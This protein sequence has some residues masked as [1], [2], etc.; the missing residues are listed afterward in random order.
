MPIDFPDSP[1][2]NQQFTAGDRTWTY[3]GTRWESVQI[4]AK[5]AYQTAV[6]NGFS[7]TEAEWVASLT[8]SD[9]DSAYTIAVSEGFVGTEAEWLESLKANY[10]ATAVSSNITLEDN[11]RY[12]V[13]TTAA[14]T[15]TLPATPALGEEIVI[16]DASGQAST[17]NITVLRNGSKINGLEDDAIID[18]DQS[19]SVFAYT[20]AT[21]GW[22]FE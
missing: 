9:G 17:N 18:L 21:V 15:L 22:R 14:R 8:G 4:E 13:D 10:P 3:D 7:G 19:I 11:N 1:T 16:Y 12:F 5:S 20:G 2:L 6:D